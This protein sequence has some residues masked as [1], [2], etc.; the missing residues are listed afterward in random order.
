LDPTDGARVLLTCGN[1]TM[2]CKV[3]TLIS[4]SRIAGRR[5][6]QPDEIAE[7]FGRD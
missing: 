2:S 5:G 1:L 6:R 7:L 4:A 3:G